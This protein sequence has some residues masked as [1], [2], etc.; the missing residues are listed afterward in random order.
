MYIYILYIY[1]YVYAKN[2]LFNFSPLRLIHFGFHPRAYVQNQFMHPDAKSHKSDTPP[3]LCVRKIW[4][5]PICKR[6][7]YNAYISVDLSKT[8]EETKIFGG[9][10]GNN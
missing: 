8:L 5:G 6:K 3:P 1:I 2:I 10:G 4:M 7:V 9:K